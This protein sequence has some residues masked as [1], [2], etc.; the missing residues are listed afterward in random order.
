[1]YGKILT[2]FLALVAVSF[3]G[4]GVTGFYTLDLVQP[5]CQDDSDCRYSVCCEVYGQSYGVCD[6]QE[7]CDGIYFAT[8]AAATQV[9]ETQS[10]PLQAPDIGAQASQ[11]YVAL[12]LGLFI[13]FVIAVISYVEWKQHKA[14]KQ[15]RKSKK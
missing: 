6:Q 2:V 1:M 11:S 3:I 5:A 12:A 15:K 14:P 10:T 13:L 9:K 4:Y 7:N 8:R